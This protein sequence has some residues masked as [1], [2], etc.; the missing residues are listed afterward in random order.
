MRLAVDG[1]LA[2]PG[3][4]THGGPQAG[5]RPCAPVRVAPSPGIRSRSAAVCQC[6]AGGIS[7]VGS[8]APP[9]Q[10]SP[11]DTTGALTD[12][13]ANPLE[14]AFATSTG[15][16]DAVQQDE[17]EIDFLGESTEG[18]LHLHL[19][20]SLR[21]GKVGV[22]N[23]FG[24]QQLDDI[25]D[26]PLAKLK[27]ATQSVLD[28]L[29]V[30]ESFPDGNPQR[31]IYC[32][33]TLNLRS[34][35]AIGYDMDYTLIHYDV[36]AWE[37]RA[38]EYGLET[39][40]Q[41][42]VPVDGLRFDPDLVIRGLIMDKEFGNLIKV[43][44]FGLVKRAMHGTRMLNWQEIRELYGREVVNLRNEG[45]WVFL[46]TL[47]S[48][49]EA[50]MYMQL[51]DRLDL[52]MFQVGTGNI[53]YQALYGMVSKA[54][55]RTH[56]EGKLKAEIIQ[57]PERYVE[58]D[59][60]MAQ[61]L[62]DQRDSGKQ[63]L[64]ITNSDYEYT[65]KMMSF[66]YD[67]F[68]PSGMRWRDLFDMV[69]VM[70][71]KP[72][73]FNYNMSLYEV[74]TPDG[75]MR[76]VLGACKG[77]LYCGGSARMVEKA[78]GVEGDDLLYVGDHI[79]TD[80]AL[81]KINFRW[82]TALVI[83]ELELEIDALARGRPHRDAL[84]ELM[85]KKELIGDVFNQLRLSRQRWVHGHTANASFEDEEGINETLAQLLMVMEHLDDRIG[86]ALERDGEHFNKRW[87]YLS[88]AGLNDKSQLNRQIEK[89]A[90]IYTSR[91]SNFLRYTPYS[92]FRS[93]SQSL[94][95]DRNL[96]RYYERTYVK[97]QQQAAAAAAAV[98][99]AAGGVGVVAGD[100]GGNGTHS[101]SSNGSSSNAFS[102]SIHVGSNGYNPYDPND[103]DSDPE[104]EQD[105]V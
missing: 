9:S 39:L 76:P 87:G 22:I 44:R 88:R 27:A 43:D 47:F 75:L 64:L 23:V 95:H 52:G 36:N 6:S 70:A 85:M 54:L 10:P 35:K 83:R 13:S 12:L 45:R 42:G 78:L 63:L 33:R 21:K 84:K 3:P 53:S 73:F 40:R 50:V 41:Q 91:V 30:P 80:A 79:Y 56:V 7:G 28:V 101:S 16:V 68:L 14:E 60:E 72:D 1:R 82:R 48:V 58:L 4:G 71:R 37:G 57:A 94:A 66:A 51:V 103:P 81:A 105:V 65:N 74:V 49:S 77:G 104:H 19:V 46:N 2:G 8:P 102:V 38:Y 69:I 67:P 93:P 25:Y 86:P 62:L 5:R 90:D 99:A 92:Y 18:N 34:I 55:Y 61:T 20:D 17:A 96:T 11:A 89:Y 15:L 98:A 31:A 100:G 24:M 32:S 29:D 59:P 26:L 97:K